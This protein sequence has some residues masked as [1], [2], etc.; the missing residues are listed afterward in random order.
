MT[1]VST[2]IITKNVAT[3]IE[4]CLQS[5]QWTD[6]IIVIDSGST[7][8]TLS[9]CRKY[10]NH[11]HSADWPGFGVQKNRALD[12]ATGEWILA[13]DA[14]EYLSEP[15]IASIQQILANKPIHAAYAMHRLSKFCGQYLK[16]GDWKNDWV[17]RLFQKNQARFNDALVHERLIVNGSNGK[18]KGYMYH[19][20]FS[21]FEE[22][23]TKV[24]L[25][26]TLS[27]QQQFDQ[28][29]K[30]SLG[31]AIIRGVWTFVRCYFLKKGFLDGKMGFM[32]AVSAAEGTYYRYL[33]LMSLTKS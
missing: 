16:H 28:H 20:S 8:E 30:S 5:V 15:L 13:I 22:V 12:K 27:A 1:T 19:N 7:D 10:T 32:M 24:N 21:D 26:S 2:I 33:K 4:R 3:H 31:K 18:L 23:L 11:I 14:D 6:E 25:Y 17:V 9:I 29:K